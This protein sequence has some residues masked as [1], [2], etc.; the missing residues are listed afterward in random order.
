MKKENHL[1]TEMFWKKDV[2]SLKFNH[3]INENKNVIHEIH[4]E[5]IRHQN[6]SDDG[7]KNKTPIKGVNDVHMSGLKVS[8]FIKDKI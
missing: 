7:I 2:F 3:K 4:K 6:S 1:K 5:N 8:I